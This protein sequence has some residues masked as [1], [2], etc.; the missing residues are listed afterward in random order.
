MNLKTKFSLIFLVVLFFVSNIT[1]AQNIDSVFVHLPSKINPLLTKQHKLKLLDNYKKSIADSVQNGFSGKSIVLG[2]SQEKNYIK[3]LNSK[4]SVMEVFLLNTE[5]GKQLIGVI[6]TI[7]DTLKNSEIK[8]YNTD[9][10]VSGMVF[11]KPVV[12][13]WIVEN[14]SSENGAT[15]AWAADQVVAGFITLEFDPENLQIKAQ[16]CFLKYISN[17]EKS[18]IEPYFKKDSLVFTLKG[19]EWGKFKD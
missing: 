8:F 2:Y 16:P 17:D 9:W 14:S 7:G 5:N 18:I 13:A 10:T 15:S 1:I 4:N 19:N 6:S 11:K 12:K 3:V